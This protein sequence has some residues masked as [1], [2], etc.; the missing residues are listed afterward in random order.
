[1]SAV[2]PVGVCP[3]PW[4][5]VAS[6]CGHSAAPFPLFKFL[7]FSYTA[8][9][10]LFLLIKQF[11]FC[12]LKACWKPSLADVKTIQLF[13]FPFYDCTP[14]SH[15]PLSIPL[16]LYLVR[17]EIVEILLCPLWRHWSLILCPLGK[18]F[19]FISFP[20][21]APQLHPVPCESVSVYPLSCESVSASSWPMSLSLVTSPKTLHVWCENSTTYSLVMKKHSSLS[22]P[23]FSSVQPGPLSSPCL[24]CT[25]LHTLWPA[26]V[27]CCENS[28]WFFLFLP[29]GLRLAPCE[30]GVNSSCIFWQ[31]NTGV[32]CNSCALPCAVQP[33]PNP[34][35]SEFCPSWEQCI[36]EPCLQWTDC[37]H[38]IL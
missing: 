12:N 33:V 27:T 23:L 14:V 37:V 1:V 3:N 35:H 31:L 36:T 2:R 4:Y 22:F 5:S 38:T 6:A 19:G 21:K 34:E 15:F 16:R 20:V 29:N 9:T 17:S 24:T 7:H 8:L 10:L 30:H 25:A 11:T 18:H 26:L 32:L 13:G 28:A